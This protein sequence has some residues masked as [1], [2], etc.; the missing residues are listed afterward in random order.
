[1]N[2][3]RSSILA[4]TLVYWFCALFLGGL[5]TIIHGGC[6]ADQQCVTEKQRLS[7]AIVAI[8]AVIYVILLVRRLRNSGGRAD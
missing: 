5:I 8:A 4:F 1:V 3:R 6:F 2:Q 7:I